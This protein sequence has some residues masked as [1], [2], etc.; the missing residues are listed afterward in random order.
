MPANI[1]PSQPF[2]GLS[3]AAPAYLEHAFAGTW[4][5]ADSDNTALMGLKQVHLSARDGWKAIHSANNNLS[6]SPNAKEKPLET[7]QR[8]ASHA[9]QRISMVQKAAA[10]AVENA[11]VNL[12]L[13][14]G[15]LAKHINP[16]DT[17]SA[18]AAVMAEIRAHVKGIKDHD[19]R[20]A[21]ITRAFAAN[22]LR[23]I[24]AVIG[25]PS[26]LSGTND[27]THTRWRDDF[28]QAAAPGLVNAHNNLEKGIALAQT[29]AVSIE[30]HAKE[31]INFS[32]AS[33]LTAL[34]KELEGIV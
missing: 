31:I 9:R 13:V 26:Y 20:E 2:A 7:L 21:F 10:L 30:V 8:I 18:D 24:R 1:D 22:D 23:T 19:E 4:D 29:A 12:D 5:I 11:Q 25:A 33:D 28:L 16:P 17:S 14:N 15:Q 6:R 27:L 34:A 3:K 32:K